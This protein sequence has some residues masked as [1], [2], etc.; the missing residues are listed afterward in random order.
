M[1][2]LAQTANVG[3]EGLEHI[4]GLT[5]LEELNLWSTLVDDSGL[6]YLAGMKKMKWLKL[7]QCTISDEG[8][9]SL[10]RT[11]SVSNLWLTNSTVLSLRIEV[12]MRLR[13]RLGGRVLNLYSEWKSDALA[14]PREAAKP[15][16]LK[17]ISN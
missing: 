7:D 5:N 10:A 13:A 1:L 4:Q 11:I 15:L 16:P 12:G 6:P 3:N 2:D 9:K 14:R 17:F 8:L